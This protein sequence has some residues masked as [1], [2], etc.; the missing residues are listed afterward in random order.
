VQHFLASAP[1]GITSESYSMMANNDF[2]AYA[3]PQGLQN[4]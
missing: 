1:L 2:L 3:M 4:T